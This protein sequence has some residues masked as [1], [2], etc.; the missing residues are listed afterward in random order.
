MKSREVAIAVTGR[1]SSWDNA[2]LRAASRCTAVESTGFQAV[3]SPGAHSTW[4]WPSTS[5]IT[6][7]RD[8]LGT[9]IKRPVGRLGSDWLS[10]LQDNPPSSER[11]TPLAAAT[12]T[13]SGS[14]GEAATSESSLPKIEAPLKA[15]KFDQ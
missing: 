7:P 9:L 4:V 5:D 1:F 14:R 8:P 10:P 2:L 6:T 3:F 11:H 15:V 12:T 13:S